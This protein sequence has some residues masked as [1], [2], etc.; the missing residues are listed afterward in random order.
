MIM[1]SIKVEIFFLPKM[2]LIFDPKLGFNNVFLSRFSNHNYDVYKNV[3]LT[4]LQVVVMCMLYAYKALFYNVRHGF[5][6]Y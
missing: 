3:R 1:T 5:G 4:W 2:R 6:S